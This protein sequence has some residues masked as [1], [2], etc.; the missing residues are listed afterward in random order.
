MSGQGQAIR[1]SMQDVRVMGRAT[2]GVRLVHLKEHDVLVA[3]EKLL[4]SAEEV[5]EESNEK[6]RKLVSLIENSSSE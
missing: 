1:I 4:T 3:M 2:Q 6:T 5:N